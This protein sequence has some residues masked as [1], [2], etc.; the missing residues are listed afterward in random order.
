MV[1]HCQF[2][3]E[4]NDLSKSR[5]DEQF[6]KKELTLSITQVL[7]GSSRPV[8]LFPRMSAKSHSCSKSN[9]AR[10]HCCVSPAVNRCLKLL[11][12]KKKERKCGPLF[13]SFEWHY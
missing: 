5:F 4:T 1:R 7:P 12:K 6:L 3:E 9:D 11:I 10:V 2:K 13:V 8:A